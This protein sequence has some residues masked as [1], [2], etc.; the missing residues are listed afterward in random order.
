MTAHDP[1]TAPGIRSWVPVPDESDFPIQ[2]LP[3]GVF[4]LADEPPRVGVAI[5]EDVLD[6]ALLQE[7]GLFGEVSGLPNGV[8]GHDSLNAFLELGRPVWRAVR[9]R[10]SGLLEEGNREI[11]ERSGLAERALVP[12]G[13]AELT[14]PVRVGDYVDFYSSLEHATNLGKMFRPGGEPLMPNWR[15]L[16]VGYHGRSGT[17]VVSGTP[18]R[19][20][21]GQLPPKGGEAPGWGPTRQLDIELEVGFVTGPGNA[22]GARIPTSEVREHVFG[23]V[24][25]NDWSARDVQRWEYQPLG[26]FLGKS[27]ATSIS[28]WVVTMDALEPYRVAGPEQDPPVLPYLQTDKPWAFDVRLE[29]RLASEEMRRRR[30]LSDVVSRTEFRRMYWNIAQQLAHATANGANVRPGDLYASGTISG[31]EP[32]SR[33][34]LIELTWRGEHPLRLP[35]GSERAFLEDGDEVT[36][37]GHAGGEGRPRIGFGEVSGTVLPASDGK[38]TKRA[39]SVRATSS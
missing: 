9:E 37:A 16:P 23:L 35:D 8:F 14:L 33:G 5:G 18:V 12:M 31:P 20:P 21:H 39:P 6:L 28:P 24:L 17:V 7:A 36:L 19:R 11:C 13:Q 10:V 25:V 4:R 2:N 38:A 27:F 3:Y 15:H 30:L 29:V 34:S 32:D 26:P 1:T 22:L